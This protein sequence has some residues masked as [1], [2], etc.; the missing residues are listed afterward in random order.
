MNNHAQ[1]SDAVLGE[2]LRAGDVAALRQ[3][4]QRH[5]E[6][7]GVIA[8]IVTGAPDLAAD[9]VQE[10]FVQLWNRRATI[11]PARD[12]AGLLVVMTRNQALM[13]LRHERVHERVSC[14]LVFL[15][16]AD[17][18]V[19]HTNE[20]VRAIDAEELWAAVRA[21]LDGLPPRCREIFLLHWE[22]GLSYAEI[23]DVLE[24][25]NA[26]IRNQMS[27]AMKHVTDVMG[28]PPFVLWREPR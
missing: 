8:E 3:L 17:A 10:A 19:I 25:S 7:L 2:R 18:S 20:G 14:D 9:A 12:L 15:A 4:M 5:A 1:L 6:R 11:D 13:L 27:R 22:A 26:T 23:E 16:R 24:I 21:V 28:R